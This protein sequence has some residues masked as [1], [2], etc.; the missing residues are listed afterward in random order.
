LYKRLYNKKNELSKCKLFIQNDEILPVP[1]FYAM[2]GVL[3]KKKYF[4][5]RKLFQYLRRK[6][7][8]EYDRKY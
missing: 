8:I 4:C 5:S 1:Q 2:L 3:E 6:K 7:F